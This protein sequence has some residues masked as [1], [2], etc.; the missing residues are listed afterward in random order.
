MVK[1]RDPR[2]ALTAL[3]LFTLL[4]GDFWRYLLSWYGWGFVVAALL[5][6]WIVIA[7]RDRVDLRRIPIALGLVL[8]L[9]TISVVWSHYPGATA[10]AILTTVATAFVGV[11]VA[12][13]VSLESL[14]RALG[15]AL[16]WILGLSLAFEF[17][18]GA[19]IRQPV[20]PLWVSYDE[21]FPRAFYWSRAL[22]FEGGRIQGIPG[23]ANLLALVALLGVIVFGI[24]LARRSVGA[25]AGSGW[26]LASL[27]TLA[28]TRSATMT[29]AAL[30]VAAA[31]GIVVLARRLSGRGQVALGVGTVAVGAA[32]VTAVIVWREQLLELVGRSPD[33]TG[34]LDIWAAVGE[35]IA[36]R[37]VLGWGWISY[38]APWVE[39]FDD[40]VVINGVT[41]LQAHNA[42][43]DVLLQLGWVGVVA[44][45][46]LVVTTSARVIS[47]AVDAPHGDAAADASLR[48]LPVL[49]LT[50]LLV[51]SLTESR[52]L[53][54][55]GLL[56]LVWLAAASRMRGFA[57]AAPDRHGTVTT[58]AE[59]GQ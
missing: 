22:L 47:W 11:V 30:G 23:N 19:F 51:Q 21:P 9:M 53:I 37:P 26:M 7:V 59:P 41:Y 52:L 20:L 6:G 54:E 18:V 58:D 46:I 40:L 39:P 12:H 1:L 27:L 34:R 48:L 17:V 45:G 10:I 38:W 43:L 24:Q 3:T 13:T 32:L 8:G 49:L 42:W 35:L 2:V 33:L 55:A 57:P 28:L 50:V 44:F 16:R 29:V 31:L 5:A 14:L 36:E 56:L 25:A 4:A 15:V